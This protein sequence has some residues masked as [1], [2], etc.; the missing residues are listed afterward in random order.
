[1]VDEKEK[2]HELQDTRLNFTK[3]RNE[4]QGGEQD[5]DRHSN[6]SSGKDAEL[7]SY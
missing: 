2:L 7:S 6:C 1:M 3:E 4:D 5:N